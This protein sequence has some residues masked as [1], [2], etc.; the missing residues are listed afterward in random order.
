[1][2]EL[3][4]EQAYDILR[5]TLLEPVR[6]KPEFI[7]LALAVGAEMLEISD[8]HFVYNLLVGS[9]K[10][11]GSLEAFHL[12]VIDSSTF[13][14]ETLQLLPRLG[15]LTKSA[16]FVF[17]KMDRLPTLTGREKALFNRRRKLAVC[18][19]LL[20]TSRPASLQVWAIFNTFWPHVY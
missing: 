7:E 5:D 9:I 17:T 11:F 12:L 16:V 4:D 2:P 20:A 15:T 8:T 13:G 19:H 6:A 14:D 18:P 10:P 3:V 1:V